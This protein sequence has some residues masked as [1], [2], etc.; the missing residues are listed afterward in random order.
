[1]LGFRAR[2]ILKCVDGF[3]FRRALHDVVVSSIAVSVQWRRSLLTWIFSE[4]AECLWFLEKGLR[5]EEP[6]LRFYCF[7]AY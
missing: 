1:M 7:A 6:N 4:A 3:L 5:L 2:S